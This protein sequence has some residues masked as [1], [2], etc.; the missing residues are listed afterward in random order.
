M[1]NEQQKPKKQWNYR[2]VN[3]KK[4][5]LDDVDK[6]ID[7]HPE[8]G[9]ASTADMVSEAIRIRIQELGKIRKRDLSFCSTITS[10]SILYN[11]ASLTR[12]SSKSKVLLDTTWLTSF[13]LST[14]S[15]M[16]YLIVYDA[17]LTFI[18][19]RNVQVKERVKLK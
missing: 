4:D 16:L 7:K 19:K 8:A 5:L 15:Y 17:Y 9:Y 2:G 1:P 18:I 6:W 13:T 10:I 14:P 12:H 11:S 3:I